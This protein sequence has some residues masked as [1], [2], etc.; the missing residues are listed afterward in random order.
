[1]IPGAEH[2]ASRARLRMIAKLST[3][4]REKKS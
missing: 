2:Q 1:M 4:S 3:D